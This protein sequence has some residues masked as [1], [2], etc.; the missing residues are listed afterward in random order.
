MFL[1]DRRIINKPRLDY[2]NSD[3]ILVASTNENEHKEHLKMVFDRLQQNVMAQN[4]INFNVESLRNELA[5]IFNESQHLK[6]S[7]K[8]V[9]EFMKIYKSWFIDNE[10]FEN[11]M[12]TFIEIMKNVLVCNN[13]SPYTKRALDF[14]ALIFKEIIFFEE[15][16][17]RKRIDNVIAR[18]DETINSEINNDA[19][20]FDDEIGEECFDRD[21]TIIDTRFISEPT[22]VDLF[23]RNYLLKFIKA[24]D[25]FVRRNSVLLLRKTIDS[26]EEVDEN[27]FAEVLK[28]L[29]K[30]SIDKDKCVRS[31]I[32]LCLRKLQNINNDDDN[33]DDEAIK[34][35]KFHLQY[36]PDSF[37]RSVAMK[38]IG[39]YSNTI[40]VIY[41]AT[42]DIDDVVRRLAYLKIAENSCANNFSAND[43]LQLLINGHTDPSNQINNIIIKKLLPTWISDV[44]DDII[45]FLEYF[46]IRNETDF[47]NT[48][49]DDYFQSLL[50]IVERDDITEFHQLVFRFKQKCMNEHK[51]P[52][53]ILPKEE[54][55]YLWYRLCNFSKENN[56]TYKKSMPISQNNDY[57]DDNANG[58]LS[59]RQNFIINDLLDDIFPDIPVYCDYI[60]SFVNNTI[61]LHSQQKNDDQSQSSKIVFRHKELNFIFQQ[62][63]NIGK[64]YKISDTAQ[65]NR[66]E[67]TFRS[68]I[69]ND[70]LYTMLNDYIEP[71]FIIFNNYFQNDWQQLLEL[72][73]DLINTINLPELHCDRIQTQSQSQPMNSDYQSQTNEQ[74][75]IPTS[76][77]NPQERIETDP[78]IL[79]RCINIC[80]SFLHVGG[81]KN[82][83]TLSS[84]RGLV[85]K[86][87]LQN[88]A[89]PESEKIRLLSVK[90]LGNYCFQS[91]VTINS[92]LKVFIE[93][94]KEENYLDARVEAL[95]Y[96]F[97][98]VGFYGL[99]KINF[100]D[101]DNSSIRNQ[102][103]SMNNS[104]DVSNRYENFFEFFSEML[105]DFLVEPSMEPAIMKKRPK[106]RIEYDLFDI[107]VRGLCKILYIGR[108]SSSDFLA[109]L[110]IIFITYKNITTDTKY[111]LRI[112]FHR[113]SENIEAF[114]DHFKT[115]NSPFNDAYV[116]CFKMLMENDVTNLNS[117][118]MVVDMVDACTNDDQRNNL[119]SKAMEIFTLTSE[120][121]LIHLNL[122]F[123]DRIID[124][125]CIEKLDLLDLIKQFDEYRQRY[126]RNN[127]TVRSRQDKC[128]LL[129]KKI[130][131]NLQLASQAIIIINNNNTNTTTTETTFN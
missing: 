41:N 43:R 76:Q 25:V 36:D 35:L 50:K 110:M 127:N 5:K 12:A 83:D 100:V 71:I 130:I 126:Q 54:C 32:M 7:K 84:L 115:K 75:L 109:K 37:V 74:Q 47:F 128:I 131:Q 68:I 55:V 22:T 30:R 56:I 99:R 80:N 92:F 89:H 44:N 48:L 4:S 91:V 122:K 108:F 120:K 14:I 102:S 82:C 61:S 106:T 38:T 121:D 96:I 6:N 129:F 10:N 93:I 63:L 114:F 104:H 78:K 31:L 103:N 19:S 88:L 117:Y 64:L 111:F 51:F 95:K 16:Y 101:S 125:K 98:F 57:D 49:L 15:E 107:A 9:K 66:I 20:D 40:E 67:R 72:A 3:D 24:D 28:E 94:L 33:D 45:R 52:S 2:Q 69:L 87:V 119:V 62:S 70:D 27:T 23:I 39:L 81:P 11:F 17:E 116:Q 113:Y 58:E 124:Y 65:W 73:L 97:D 34:I 105:L 77:L 21:K 85:N 90:A 86:L 123:I 26:L 112:F 59:Q 8:N 79:E 1:Q 60:E 18:G 13:S 42:R 46:D 29:R 53:I 118:E